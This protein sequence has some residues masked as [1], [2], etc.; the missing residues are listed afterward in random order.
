MDYNDFEKKRP[1]SLDF[2]KLRVFFYAEIFC[3]IE[4]IDS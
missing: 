2:S 3:E 4:L 1:S